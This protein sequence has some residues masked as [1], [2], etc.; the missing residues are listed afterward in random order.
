[1]LGVLTYSQ[2]VAH[3]QRNRSNTL[4]Y[5]TPEDVEK[6]LAGRHFHVYVDVLRGL[7]E[8][9]SKQMGRS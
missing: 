6:I 9:E 4:Q 8:R 3:C 5:T 2:R 7:G 1:M